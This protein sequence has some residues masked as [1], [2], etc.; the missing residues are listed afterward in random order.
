MVIGLMVG[1]ASLSA[2]QPCGN[3]NQNGVGGRPG[4]PPCRAGVNP[5]NAY[6]GNAFREITDLQV[7]GSVVPLEWIRFNN[8]DSVGH[9]FFNTPSGTKGFYPAGRQTVFDYFG[10]ENKVPGETRDDS[11][12]PFN[13][14]K[15]RSYKACPV[16]LKKLAES[17]KKHSSDEYQAGNRGARNCAGWA[18]ER[19]KDTGFNPPMPP[20]TN[21][22]RPH[23]LHP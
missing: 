23:D 12:H 8:T 14:E 3:P 17:I 1:M 16:T 18:C 21:R 13:R 19:L 15:T 9:A 10:G 5:M 2:R 20:D 6:T 11:K 4:S 22:L 7:Y